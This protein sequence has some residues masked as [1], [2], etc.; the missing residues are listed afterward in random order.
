MTR[1]AVH[2][3]ADRAT[4]TRVGAR[5]DKPVVLSVDAGAMHR[6]GHVVQVSANG[7]WLTAAVPAA[8][9]RFPG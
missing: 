9:L 2:L 8:F 3:S 6:A 7:V 1:H 4:A 5:R